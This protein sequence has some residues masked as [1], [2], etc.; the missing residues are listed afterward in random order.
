[1][2]C[3]VC[4]LLEVISDSTTSL[5]TPEKLSLDMVE[6]HNHVPGLHQVTFLLMV[7][8]NRWS[9]VYHCWPSCVCLLLTGLYTTDRLRQIFSAHWQVED[10]ILKDSNKKRKA[11]AL[12]VLS[13]QADAQQAA[14]EAHGDIKNPLLVMPYLKVVPDHHHQQQQ[15]GSSQHKAGSAADG[16]PA[17][18]PAAA[19]PKK[20]LFASG[21]ASLTSRPVQRPI[22][23]LFPGTRQRELSTQ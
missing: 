18:G 14:L 20:P 15:Q 8:A 19:G 21:L 17:A 22:K 11:S 4:S 5:L 16:S 6:L 23:P 1:M 10:V 7:P 13:S 9:L 3:I 2:G 12:V